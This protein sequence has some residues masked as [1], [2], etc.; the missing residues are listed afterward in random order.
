VPVEAAP[1]PP[2]ALSAPS[3]PK[4]LYERLG[5]ID[6]ITAVTAEF[7]NRSTSDK[8]IKERFF[9]TDA[10]NLKRLLAEFV[11][12]AS[13]GPCRYTGRDMQT[14]HAGME[15]VD[16]EF[17][18]L[19]EDLIGALDHFKVGEQDKADLLA[20][21]GPLKP[22][23]VA[24]PGQLTPLDPAELARVT[25]VASGIADP[26]ARELLELAV[27]AGTRGQRSYAEQLFTRA[28]MITQPQR[29]AKVAAVFRAGMPARV[30]TPPT[31]LADAGA[32]P[33]TVGSSEADDPVK[34][35]AAGSLRGTVK[36]D[37]NPPTGLGVVMLWPEHAGAKRAPKRRIIEQRGKAFAPH[38]MAVPVGSTV[39][40]P[41]YDPLYHDVFS[42]SKAKAFDLGM[43]KSGESREVK[44]DKPGIVRLGC[45]L[46]ANMSAYV[47]VVDAPHY[48]VVDADGSFA[49]RSLT[50]GKYRVQAWDEQSAEPMTTTLTIKAGANDRTL[51]LRGGGQPIS[52][53]KFGVSRAAPA[54]AR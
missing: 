22:Q 33:R 5:G 53:D 38:V 47:V 9:N 14:S 46:H 10:G 36:V 21:I 26:A 29:V 17:A 44:L 30:M 28:E 24:A 34:R 25:A 39:A 45:N 50:P 48:V 7:V 3:A 40:F 6:A 2:P 35:P 42:I 11:C 1:D 8:R 18:A 15:L 19:V 49:F 51:E 37:G 13:G 27:V 32:Q 12:A 23:I 43:Y 52:P 31:P 54:T 4:T 41:N 16:D 20:A